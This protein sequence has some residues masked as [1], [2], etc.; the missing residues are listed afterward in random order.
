MPP[1][2]QDE[3]LSVLPSAKTA[4]DDELQQL[5]AEVAAAKK[6]NTAQPDTH[7]YCE[8][9][10]RDKFIDLLRKEAGWQLDARNVEVQVHGM[11]NH[12]GIGFVGYVLW[13]DDGK[14]LALTEAKRTRKDA[15]AGQ[16]QARLYADCLEAQYGQRPVI[17]YSNGYEH[18]I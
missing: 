6:A 16:Q 8:A 9:E 14:P 17:F 7:D 11:P 2:E 1:R 12:Q 13:G 18:W 10:T 4:L 15:T 3:K 5:H